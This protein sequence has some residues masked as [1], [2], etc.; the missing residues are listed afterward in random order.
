MD[1]QKRYNRP[2]T[3]GRMAGA[4]SG[5]LAPLA[6]ESRA[7]AQLEFEDTVERKNWHYIPRDRQGLALKEMDASLR[8]KA[9]RL[10][11]IG[12]SESA[13]SKVRTI[14]SLEPI[15]GSIEGPGRK[16][17]RDSGLYHLSIFGNPE[18]NATWGWRFEGHHISINY[19]IVDGTFVRSTPIFFGAGPAGVRHG[20]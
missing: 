16:N 11:D 1:L 3:A 10:I 8:E 6:A 5:F 19:T 9:F 13:R 12:V 18:E 17:P 15:L 14:I 4:A 2:E 7:R 20:E